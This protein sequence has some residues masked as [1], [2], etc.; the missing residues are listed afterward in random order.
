VANTLDLFRNG[1]VGF[2]DWLGRKTWINRACGRHEKCETVRLMRL[3][4]LKTGF[5][6]G[7]IL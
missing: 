5:M 7:A 1:A 3:A 6:A 4:L 2:I